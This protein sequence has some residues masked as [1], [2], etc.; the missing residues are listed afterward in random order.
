MQWLH[1][2]LPLFLKRFVRCGSRHR[3]ETLG[4]GRL[5]AAHQGN[6]APD[7]LRSDSIEPCFDR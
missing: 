2:G 5:V 4:M 6:H 7:D 3:D 1:P